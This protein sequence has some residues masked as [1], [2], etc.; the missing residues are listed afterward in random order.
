[1]KENTMTMKIHDLIQGSAEW[2]AYRAQ[3]FNASDAPAMMGCSPYMTRTELLTR[4]KTGIT[5]DVD[6][7]TQRRF[8]DGHRFEALARPLAEKIVGGDLYPVTGSQGELSASFDGITLDD[9]TLFEHKTL[10]DALRYTPWDEGNGDHLPLHYRVQIE[11]QLLVANAER[12]LFMASKWNGDELVEERHCW[13]TSDPE[14]RAQI[15]AG[16][17]QFAADLAVFVPEAKSAPVV[18][19]PVE[20]LPA[21]SVKVDGALAIVSNLPDFGAALRTFIDKIPAQPSTDQEFADTEAACKALKRAEEALEAAETNALAQ[22]ADVDTMRRLVADFK[23]LARTTRLQREK[24][25]A[26]RKD[27]M[28]SEIVATGVASLAKFIRELNASMPGDYMPT[29]PADFGGVIKGLRTIDSI[30]NAVDTEL[31][32]A[33]VAASEIAS[34]IHANLSALQ[35]SGLVLADIPALVLKAPDDLAAVIAQRVAVAKAAEE[36][37]RERIR[38]EEVARLE[39]EAAA[40]AAAEN[41]E[42]QTPQQVLKAEAP[43]P[44]ATA[45]GVSVTASPSVGS[46]GAGQAADAAPDDGERLTLG[47]INERLAPVSISVA[48]LSELGFEP[49]QQIKASRLYRACDLPAI[50]RAISAHVMAAGQVEV[51]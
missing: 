32:R 27:H 7:A 15:V 24:L 22:L 35:A 43:A 40:R 10:G 13:Y 11:Q 16:W 23:A 41:T 30:T 33:K 19:A 48:G 45:R 51:A 38:A 4:M 14:L 5:A 47:Q 3:H 17:K 39:R 20:T 42:A 37:Q 21:V 50:C 36:A 34:R 8:D 26:A 1:L 25:V 29:V 2:H 28:K 18:A 46:M 9:S 6:A 44:D 49:A 31:A 12:V